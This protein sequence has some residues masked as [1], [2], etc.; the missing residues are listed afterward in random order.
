MVAVFL[1]LIIIPVSTIGFIATDTAKKSLGKSVEDSVTVATKQTSNYFD[2]FLDKSENISMQIIANKSVQA[3]TRANADIT[4]QYERLLAHQNASD[5][6]SS[7][8]TSS[9]DMNASVLYN[10]GYVLGNILQPD[11]MEKVLAT[12]WYKKVEKAGGK[13]VLTD[14][15]EGMNSSSTRNYALSMLRL[16]KDPI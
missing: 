15:M 9:S 1:L 12:Q 11:D 2:V 10:T 13:V 8:N 5:A 14:Y 7:I 16:Y 4:D 6:L 3:L